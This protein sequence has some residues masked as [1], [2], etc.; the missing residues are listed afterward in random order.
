MSTSSETTDVAVDTYL[1]RCEFAAR[2]A[3][4]KL[5]SG[6]DGSQ[7]INRLRRE[8]RDFWRDAVAD[9]HPSHKRQWASVL[10]A[11]RDARR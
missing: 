8:Y 11:A 2:D 6:E 3:Y 7:V 4:R 5:T 1:Y 10:T 9:F